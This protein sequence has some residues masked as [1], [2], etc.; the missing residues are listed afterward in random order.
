MRTIK[1]LVGLTA[2]AVAIQGCGGGST[3]PTLQPAPAPA[4]AKA[5]FNPALGGAGLPFPIDLL[6]SS[7]ADGSLNVPGKVTTFNPVDAPGTLVTSTTVFT[8]PLDPRTAA[9]V[10]PQTAL[11]NM[12]GFSTTAP[13]V[14]RFSSSIAGPASRTDIKD[15]VRIFRAN[16]FDPGAQGTVTVQPG[17]AAELIWGVDFVAGVSAG[18][19]LLIQP[20]KPLASSST[21]IVV[22]EDDLLS[23]SGAPVAADDTYSLV[24]GAF[25][26]SSAL[27]GTGGVSDF[28]LEAGGAPCN[29]NS[30]ASV[31]VCTD[32]NT[33]DYEFAAANVPAAAEGATTIAQTLG[34]LEA[35]GALSSIYQL[36]QLR[37][38]TAKHL[39]AVA[40]A[41]VP[42]DPTKVSLSYSISTENIGGALAAAKGQVEA[43]GT[44]PSITVLNPIS[45][46]ASAPHIAVVSP[47]ANGQLPNSETNP[48]DDD[49]VA[50]I[51]LGTL[52]DV[53]QFLD[54]AAQ[55]TS[56]WKASRAG[57]NTAGPC[58]QLP[59]STDPDGA[60]PAGPVGTENLVACNGFVAA[61]VVTD[62]SIPVIISAPRIESLNPAHPD[63]ANFEDCSGGDLPVVIYQHG[64]TSNRGTLMAIADTLASQCIVGVAID[65]PKHGILP[66]GDTFSG[67]V[68]LQA[69]L[70]SGVYQE[71]LVEVTSP[72]TQCQATTGVAIPGDTNFY[73]CPSG[74]SFINL[75]N[76]AN[77]RDALRQ[78]S[79][80]LHSLFQA[81]VENADN[82]LTA[83]TIGTTVDTDRISFVGVSLGGIVGTSFIAQQPDLTA[84]VLNVAGGGIAKILDGS[85]SF[86]PSITAGLYNGAGLIKP[87]GDYEGFLIIAQTMVD[88]ADPINFASTIAG[89]STPVMLQ[90]V[91]GD[92]SDLGSCILDGDGC[93][94]QVVPNNTFGSSFGGA[95]G[96]IAQTG[97][98]SFT[99]N[100]NFITTPVALSGSDPLA[101]GTGFVLMAGAVQSGDLAGGTALGLGPLGGDAVAGAPVTFKGMNLSTVT[102]CGAESGGVVRYT[103]GSHGS[104]L[105]PAG[106][107][108]AT[109]YAAVTQTMQ[110]QVAAFVLNDGEFIPPD[111][112]GVVFTPA[113]ANTSQAACPAILAP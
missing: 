7:T 19:S 3:G 17:A 31:A 54:P 77:A 111:Q 41:P 87:S 34:Q 81:I 38:I 14:V 47:G 102:S 57:W 13:M 24:K 25:L 94:D 4:D 93:P 88:N 36:E 40:A 90:E 105:T 69:A 10:D 75:T 66:T 22:I 29:F 107:Q 100:Q 15:G 89:G 28:V 37:R 1:K 27:T 5:V 63:H 99:A 97:Q 20:L 33:E 56:V 95:W 26:L 113:V 86:E 70:S 46:W 42:V 80:D 8:D 112:N 103:T 11:T 30:Q 59:A 51:Y 55:N 67:L 16:N 45:N 64:I 21:Y 109:Q 39:A 68:Q 43:A 83:A 12:D 84:A 71:R 73:Y 98:T 49:H 48:D 82:D 65:L 52:N 60:G 106:P 79:V 96:L 32:V 104:L 35:G 58:G 78:G 61:P 101:Q 74:D 23:L 72:M 44:A 2:L 76:L 108:G 62:H 110:R 92:P 85:P 9:M 50:H 6:F 91:I 18:T 53:I